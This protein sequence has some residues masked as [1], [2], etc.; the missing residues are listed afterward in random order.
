MASETKNILMAQNVVD[1]IA[2]PYGKNGDRYFFLDFF[3]FFPYAMRRAYLVL[4]H[5][6]WHFVGKSLHT[7]NSTV[8]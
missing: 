6:L 3:P 8:V 2:R 1:G 7:I 4:M 5:C